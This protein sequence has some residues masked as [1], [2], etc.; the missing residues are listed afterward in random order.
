VLYKSQAAVYIEQKNIDGAY[1]AIS[2]AIELDRKD[3]F[4]W[5]E[6]MPTDFL[7]GM[8]FATPRLLAC[9]LGRGGCAILP[10]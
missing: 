10:S 5:A 6:H 2:E 3:L 8:A 1:E 7:A 9:P 4:N